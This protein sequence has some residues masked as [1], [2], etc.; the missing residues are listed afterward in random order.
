MWHEDTILL[1]EA[2]QLCK[3]RGTFLRRQFFLKRNRKLFYQIFLSTILCRIIAI[4]RV[5]FYNYLIKFPTNTWRQELKLSDAFLHGNEQSGME[6]KAQLININYGNNQE[7]MQKCQTLA[8]YSIFVGK[9]REYQKKMELKDAIWLAME[10]CIEAGVLVEFLKAR[11]DEV[12]NALLTEYDEERVMKD[13]REESFEDG[14]EEGKKEGEILHLIKQISLKVHKGMPP[15]EIA[16][17]LEED[18]KDVRDIC[19]IIQERDDDDLDAIYESLKEK[20]RKTF[21]K[22]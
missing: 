11:R 21:K 16:D 5:I 4:T 3:N 13:L 6:L 17:L 2:V 14:W 18:I 8:G 7:L 15:E 19:E 22:L 20:R 10:E 1:D 9:I 12:V